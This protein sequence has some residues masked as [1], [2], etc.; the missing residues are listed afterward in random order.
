VKVKDGHKLLTQ[1]VRELEEENDLSRSIDS[2]S[3][4]SV[5]RD[6]SILNV[7]I[8]GEARE[9]ILE[10]KRQCREQSINEIAA[11][12]IISGTIALPG[13]NGR[14]GKTNS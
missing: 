2:I 9:F 4:N 14:C 7:E 5:E 1:Y 6:A 13:F 12:L 8:R 11:T 10:L 3:E